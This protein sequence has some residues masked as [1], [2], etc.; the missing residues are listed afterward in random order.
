MPASTQPY[1]PLVPR[2]LV[3]LAALTGLVFLMTRFSYLPKPVA[4]SQP[5]E[6]AG[7]MATP[8]AVEPAA[9]KAARITLGLRKGDRLVYEAPTDLSP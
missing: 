7:E 3:V 5:V 1:P 9:H 6:V 2:S 8:A 4:P